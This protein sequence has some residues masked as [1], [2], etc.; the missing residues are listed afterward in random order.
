MVPVM[1][2]AH[3]E[4]PVAAIIASGV[5]GA[6]I[7]AGI[8]GLA[9]GRRWAFWTALAC[10]IVD[11][12]SAVP[13][14]ARGPAI[15]FRRSPRLRWCCPSPPS[16]SSGSAAVVPSAPPALSKPGIQ[17]ENDPPACPPDAII[18]PGRGIALAEATGGELVL[19][20]GSGHGPPPPAR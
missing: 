13:G 15:A 7:L 3:S 20:E 18:G 17:P 6:A 9:Q 14:T 8:P 12:A 1:V 11:A 19:L 2:Q 16:C 5:R 4:P 10:R